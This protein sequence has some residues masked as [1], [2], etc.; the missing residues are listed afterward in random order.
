MVILT[1]SKNVHRTFIY[2]TTGLLKN[3][4]IRKDGLKPPRWN[5]KFFLGKSFKG[6]NVQEKCVICAADWLG[7]APCQLLA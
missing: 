3:G 7:R 4:I 6:S 1:D 5:L 2:F